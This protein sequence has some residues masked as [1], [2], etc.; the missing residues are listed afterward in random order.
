MILTERSEVICMSD[1]FR[2][3]L[4]ELLLFFR[5]IYRFFFKGIF[6]ITLLL[7]IANH[8]LGAGGTIGKILSS[9][10]DYF[11]IIGMML[12]AI[13]ALWLYDKIIYLVMPEDEKVILPF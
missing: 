6:V 5:G 10:S 11:Y 3:M 1:A 12:F 9:P 7:L 8:F 2:K 13:F 4:L